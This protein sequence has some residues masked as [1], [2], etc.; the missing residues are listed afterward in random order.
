[1]SVVVANP[2]L[3]KDAFEKLVKRDIR[4][5]QG[6]RDNVEVSVVI[7][8]RDEPYV[9]ELTERLHKALFGY[10]HDA[11]SKLNELTHN[12]IIDEA[13]K[14]RRVLNQYGLVMEF[15]APRLW[16]DLKL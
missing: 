16:E 4:G 7:P 10:N 11:L 1:M 8:F 2:N 15:V 3:K 14:L 13:R 9:G 6:R 5:C 12:Q